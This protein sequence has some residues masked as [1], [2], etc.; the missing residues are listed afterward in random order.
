MVKFLLTVL[1][2]VQDHSGQYRADSLF[3]EFSTA[4]MCEQARKFA[5]E[6]INKTKDAL[7]IDARC[8]KVTEV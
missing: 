7:V 6:E 8:V 4:G 3:Q 5:V 1:I 2:L